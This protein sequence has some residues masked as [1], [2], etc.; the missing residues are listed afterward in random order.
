M[1]GQVRVIPATQ[2][3]K[4]YSRQRIQYLPTPSQSRDGFERKRLSREKG[5]LMLV[6]AGFASRPSKRIGPILL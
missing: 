4:R 1:T 6:G 2:T 3:S 5:V